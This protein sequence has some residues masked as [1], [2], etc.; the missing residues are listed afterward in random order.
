MDNEILQKTVPAVILEACA[1]HGN[2]PAF[3]CLGRTL[4]YRDLEW[5]SA[6]FAAWLQRHTTLKPGDRIAIQLPNILQYP[7]AVLGALRAGLVLVNTNPL[8]SPPELQ[9]Q[10]QDSGARALVVL[11][12]AAARAA[13]GIG[14]TQVETVI[15]TEMADLHRFPQREWI[16][17][18][19]K[20]L[21]KKVPP[22]DLPGSVKFTRA[23]KPGGGTA[24]AKV[25]PPADPELRD[26]MALQYTGG[27]TGTSKGAMLTH[28][29]LV[30][31]M[32]QFREHL[33]DDCPEPGGIMAAPLP[34]Y[35]IY[36][37]TVH[38]LYCLH[39][40]LHNLLIPNPQDIRGLVKTMGRYPIAGFIGI[41][42]LYNAL[43]G[44]REFARLD[45]S[46]LK[47][48]T[49]GGMA[50]SEKTF[51]RWRELTG[52]SILE[53]YGLTETSPLVA[54]N[55]SASLQVGTIG[56]PVVDTQVKVV[57]M[58]GRELPPGEPGE[59]C[60]KGPQVMKG[61]WRKP[62][63]TSRV[64]DPDGWLH[65]GDVAVIQEDGFIR[66]VD[67]IKDMII[68]SGF[69]VYPAEIEEYVCSHPDVREAAAVGVKRGDIGGEKVK[70]YVV[71]DNPGLSRQEI[72]AWCEKGLAS[73]KVP[74]VIEFCDALPK[75][76]VGKILRRELRG[77]PDPVE[78][79]HS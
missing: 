64:L 50:L 66:I 24:P 45:L 48:S 41:N 10:L 27:T 42:T 67:R 22:Y 59:L 47:I 65:T 34:L 15:V 78:Q 7:V 37:F 44:S 5:L 11:A 12:G 23:L 32:H 40:G 31:N 21:K 29:N 55:R 72:I 1:R 77:E 74:R 36:G 57:D 25:E 69:N 8:Y 46:S 6:R 4:T 63:E 49:A 62:E 38:L 30:A 28:A 73:Y 13:E 39:Q 79:T 68:V 54:C 53:G 14:G 61:Y 70:L 20:H 17:F 76:N 16:N 52:C 2:R 58:D 43:C 56:L 9:R 18:A 35:H 71:T 3:T 51:W 26:L 33:K 19:L 60:V 75:S